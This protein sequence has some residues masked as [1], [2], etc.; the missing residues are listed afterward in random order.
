M[1]LHLEHIRSESSSKDGRHTAARNDVHLNLSRNSVIL[2]VCIFL[3]Y[4]G[5]RFIFKGFK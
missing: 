5:D 4:S 3:Q 2:I 1:I